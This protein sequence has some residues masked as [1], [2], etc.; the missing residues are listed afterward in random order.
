MTKHCPTCAHSYNPSEDCSLKT[1]RP[2]MKQSALDE[3]D[4]WLATYQ[5]DGAEV[6]TCPKWSSRESFKFGLSFASSRY[7]S[8]CSALDVLRWLEWHDSSDDGTSRCPVCGWY[9]RYGHAGNCGLRHAINS[10][11]PLYMITLDDL[12]EDLRRYAE[13]KESEDDE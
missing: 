10:L 13:Q 7:S 11:E 3:V 9:E 1:T 12:H 2:L 5:I 8:L 4:A 6:G